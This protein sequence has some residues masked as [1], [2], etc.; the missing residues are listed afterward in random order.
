MSQVKRDEFVSEHVTD[1]DVLALVLGL[2]C[3]RLSSRFSPDQ[4]EISNTN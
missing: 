3:V 4:F 1:W 2:A